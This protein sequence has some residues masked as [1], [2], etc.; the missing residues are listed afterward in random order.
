MWKD[1]FKQSDENTKT[2]LFAHSFF[3]YIILHQMHLI[4]RVNKMNKTITQSE[5]FH[6]SIIDHV[7]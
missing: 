1:K 2:Q 4:A 6:N 5:H 3:E 7:L